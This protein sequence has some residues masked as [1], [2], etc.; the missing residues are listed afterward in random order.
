MNSAVLG[1][2]VLELGWRSG[3]RH[4]HSFQELQQLGIVRGLIERVNGAECDPTLLVNDEHGAV[5]DPRNRGPLPQNAKLASDVAVRIHVAEQRVPNHAD[6]ALLP[7]HVTG[8]RI[9][10][11]AQDLGVECGELV[12]IIVERRHLDGSGGCPVQRVKCEDNMLPATIVSQPDAMTLLTSDRRQ[13]E[14]GRHVADK[15]VRHKPSVSGRSHI[16]DRGSRDGQ[17]P[18]V[19]RGG[20]AS[21]LAAARRDNSEARSQEKCKRPGC[22]C[23]LEFSPA[24]QGFLSSVAVR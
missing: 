22:P 17:T 7:R 2:Q 18:T 15:Q 21:A 5:I 19:R 24:P 6:R 8:K 23:I 11:Y 20:R 10:A 14:I 13:D 4:A 9:D 3:A 16:L 12:Q 1:G